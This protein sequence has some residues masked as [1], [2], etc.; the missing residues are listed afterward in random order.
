M[1]AE[2]RPVRVASAGKG[3]DENTRVHNTDEYEPVTT[4]VLG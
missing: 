2:V 1:A 3:G 4:P